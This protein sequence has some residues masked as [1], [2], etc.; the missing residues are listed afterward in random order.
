MASALM[1]TG[2]T[3]LGL[4]GLAP[5]AWEQM[6]AIFGYALVSCLVVNDA[7]KVTMIK[8]PVPSAVA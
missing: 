8:R 4:P 2:L 3:F 5:L 1:G 7:V 6:L